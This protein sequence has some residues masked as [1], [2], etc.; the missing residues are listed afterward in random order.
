MATNG[1]NPKAASTQKQKDTRFVYT[2]ARAEE[3]RAATLAAQH[4]RTGQLA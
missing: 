1:D 4:P 2:R 3:K